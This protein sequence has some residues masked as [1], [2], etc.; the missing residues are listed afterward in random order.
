M[1]ALAL[2]DVRRRELAAGSV[3]EGLQ[4][5]KGLQGHANATIR[6]THDRK[7]T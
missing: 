5:P 2:V 7:S 3:E 1:T 6:L 4:D